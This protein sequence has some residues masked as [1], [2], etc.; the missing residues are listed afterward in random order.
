MGVTSALEGLTLAAPLALLLLIPAAVL[1]ASRLRPERPAHAVSDSG[2]LVA[3]VRTTVRMRVRW[4]PD[5]LRALAVLLLVL[6]IARPREG[7]AVTTLPEDGIDVVAVVDVSSSMQQGVSATETRLDAARRVLDEF[8]ETLEG[9][10]LGLVAFQS[11]ALTLSPLTNDVRAIQRRIGQLEPG[12]VRDGTAIGLG[13]MEG[14]SLLRE[15]PARSRVIVL[16]TDGSN[17]AGEV[18][19]F[20]AARV[21]EAFGIRIYTIG[22]TSG[23]QF[24]PSIDPS[25]LT[26]LAEVTGGAFFDAATAEDLKA[27]YEEIGSLERSRIGERRFVSFREYGPWLA[28][29]AAALLAVDLGLRSTWLRRQP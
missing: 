23:G 6:S 8:A 10:R 5:V 27:A 24:A 18:R 17:N 3:A 28:L 9:D 7:L 2:P 22:L 29:A 25:G 12:L 19:P 11:R 4:L 14:V 15:S 26:E 16:L 21:A 1:F 20:E 13:V